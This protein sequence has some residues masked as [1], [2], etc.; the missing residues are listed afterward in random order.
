MN[1]SST[2]SLHSTDNGSQF[3]EFNKL[4]N[5]VPDFQKLTAYREDGE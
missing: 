2:D 5:M 1:D 4:L 3:Q